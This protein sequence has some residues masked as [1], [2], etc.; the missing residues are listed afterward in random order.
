MGFEALQNNKAHFETS[1]LKIDYPDKSNVNPPVCYSTEALKYAQT[2]Y[3]VA[4]VVT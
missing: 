1:P 4:I 2:A 3:F